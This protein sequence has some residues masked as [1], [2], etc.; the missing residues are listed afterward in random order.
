[1][2]LIKNCMLKKGIIT[3]LVLLFCG[4]GFSQGHFILNKKDNDKI[5]FKL[6]DN[7]IV[8]PVEV[9]GLELSFLLDSG[10]SKPIL[11]N[12][13]N[14][15]SLQIK[16]VETIYLR[17]L[18]EGGAV[19]AL[20]S[21]KNVLKLGNAIN[22][23]QDI[24]VIFDEKINFTPRLGIP[25]HGIIGYDIFKDF[26]VEINYS[27][28]VIKLHNPETY[29]Y[30]KC[31]KC[32]TFGLSFFNRKP[33]ID[34]VVEINSKKIPIKLLIDTGSSDSLWLFE[35]DS[36]G[37]SSKY[38]KHFD[39]FLGKGLSGSIY[40]KRS[41]VTLFSL[42]NFKLTDVNVAFPDSSSISIAKNIKSRNGSLSSE[43]L[44]RF[45]IIMD[46]KNSKI[47]LRKNGNFNSSFNYN[48]SGIIVEHQGVRVVKKIERGIT[49]NNNNQQSQTETEIIISPRYSY[50]LKPAFT[51]VELRKDSPAAK[52]GLLVGD[53]ILVIN[54]KEAHTLDLQDINGILC[55]DHGKVIKLKVDRNG[56][57]LP[58]RFKLED[59]FR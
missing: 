46:Y 19:E 21:R 43:I 40:G 22:I 41:K 20:R 16:N 6:I 42:K 26:I 47:T 8:L 44:R 9:N 38:D 10:V 3:F 48:K 50:S 11:F 35:D 24:Y 13:V 59:F 32:E 2:S 55:A 14:T 1:M 58:F 23:N 12:L 29:I 53:I 25:I 28:K 4:L 31:K 45:N 52:A 17:G 57:Q 5:R 34:G 27:T 39:D 51:I 18:G 56:F 30:K 54:G 33:Y 15:D 49:I 37:I 36:L 7:L